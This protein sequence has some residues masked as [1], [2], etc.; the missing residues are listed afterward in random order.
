MIRGGRGGRGGE[1]NLE[2]QRRRV[3]G[4]RVGADTSAAV[5]DEHGSATPEVNPHTRIFIVIPSLAMI[6]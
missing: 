3:R 6:G 4:Q 2:E 5:A 1:I